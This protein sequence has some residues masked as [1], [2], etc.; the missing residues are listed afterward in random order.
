[1]L[2]GCGKRYRSLEMFGI[3]KRGWI[4]RKHIWPG[5]EAVVADA[6]GGG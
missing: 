6:T 5:V 2:E 3:N 4:G 1:M